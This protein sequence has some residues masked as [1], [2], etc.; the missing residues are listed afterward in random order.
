M[1][2][3]PAKGPAPAAAAGSAGAAS[4]TETGNQ[5]ISPKYRPSELQKFVLVWTKK[6]KS[7][8]EIPNFVS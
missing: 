8:A 4:A 7:K 5:N 1:C 3:Q 6:Y 2:S